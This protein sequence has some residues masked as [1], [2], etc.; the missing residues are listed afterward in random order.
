VRSGLG[1]LGAAGAVALVAATMV[2]G[3][4]ATPLGQTS[5]ESVTA[6]HK[7][8]VMTGSG[9][10]AFTRNFNPYTG[11]TLNGGLVKGAFYEP[12]VVA[13]VA[14]GGHLYPWLAQSWKWTNGNKTLTLHIRKGVKW[15]D[16]TP[17]TAAD[18]AYS[19]NAGKQNK[20]M[21]IIGLYRP[22][23]NIEHMRQTGPDTVAITLKKADSQFIAAQL[24][25]QFV[26]PRHIW[27]HVKN[28]ATFTNPNPV[29]S[30]PFTVISR[31]T[32]QD[33]V[34]SK[35]PTYWQPGKPLI[36][37]MEYQ[38][39]A[40]NDSA[41]ILM[42]SGK[43]DWTHNFVPNV[44]S[45]YESKDK[46]HFHAFYATTAYPVSLMF[47]DTS[48]PFS[49]VAL[50]QA[51]SRAIN[52]NEVSKLGEYGY[53]PPADAIGLNGIF[54]SWVSDPA[55]KAQAK[56]MASYDPAAAKQILTGAGFTY[57]G[58][59]LLDPHGNPVS[60]QIH[61]ISGWSDWVAS[62]QI[63]TKNLQAIGIDATV[64][65]E[66]SYNTWYPGASTTKT[67]TLLWQNASQG[68]PYGFF[69]S[70]LSSNSFTPSGQ[71]AT[72]TGNWEHFQSAAATG[73]LDQWKGTLSPVVQHKAATKLEQLWL[74]NLPVVPLFIGPRWSTYS[75]RYF[76]CFTSPTNFY[77]DPIFNAFPDDVVNF[78]HICPGGQAGA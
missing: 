13:T 61:V 3:A 45:A 22:N 41:L 63:V 76:H 64:A 78:T 52:R 53:A 5:T 60:F 47:D 69:F 32:T 67:P 48:Y 31:L 29:G 4:S 36:P 77:A 55:V 66:P 75:T 28:P 51:M 12:L 24:N 30:G 43:V 39:S 26:V 16:G 14:G 35:N 17:L 27:A 46:A 72:T 62:L 6:G 7:C 33:F 42:Q 71:D 25:L 57:K 68:S 73:I 15:S 50:R 49:L 20:A 65:L 19:L 1:A 70:N 2:Q 8:L 11:S 10:A 23:T 74:Q 9:D 37:C 40:S 58:S 34:L 59:Q 18:V 56:T 38:E 54:P 21:D 44:A